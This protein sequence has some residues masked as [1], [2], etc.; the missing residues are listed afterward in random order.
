MVIDNTGGAVSI[1]KER[2]FCTVCGGDEE[3]CNVNVYEPVPCAAGVPV[4]A[5]V[6]VSNARL[7]GSA[8][9]TDQLYGVIPPD[10]PT[11]VA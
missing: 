7:A 10:P 3:S 2:D 11:A 6:V 1:V 9:A 8:G 4:I 5:P